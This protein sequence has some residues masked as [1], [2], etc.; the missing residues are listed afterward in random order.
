MSEKA[1][2]ELRCAIIEHRIKPGEQLDADRIGT[3]FGFSRAPVVEALGL[4]K[5]EGLVVTRQRVGTFASPLARDRLDDVFEARQMIEHWMVP[6]IVRRVSNLQLEDLSALLDETRALT[7]AATGGQAFDYRRY[8]HLDQEFHARLVGFAG[9]DLYARWFG[10]LAAHMQR[11]R[12][13]FRGDPL[14]RSLDGQREH[15]AIL[16]A[17]FA[18]DGEAAREGLMLHA[19]RSR[20]G[21]LAIVEANQGTAG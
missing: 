6:D 3:S 8:M 5:A 18:R 19:A 21:A 17:F 14:P 10:E 12:N 13:L 16:A 4:L 20:T 7:R 11:V 15:E 1:Y 9:R 2:S